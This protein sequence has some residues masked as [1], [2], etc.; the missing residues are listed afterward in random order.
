MFIIRDVDYDDS[1]LRVD[2]ALTGIELMFVDG[3]EEDDQLTVILNKNQ[4]QQI[5]DILEGR[6]SKPVGNYVQLPQISK[7]EELDVCNLYSFEQHMLTLERAALGVTFT[8]ADK[9]LLVSF[10][11]HYL[12]Q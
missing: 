11:N 9:D 6:T 8:P 1:Y 5:V 7:E 2:L 4:L 10:I 12:E 3:P